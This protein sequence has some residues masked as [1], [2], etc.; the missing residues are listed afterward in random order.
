MTEEPEP[1]IMPPPVVAA[2]E[3]DAVR[4]D[5]RDAV[6]ERVLSLV[7][8]K[9]VIQKTCWIWTSISKQTLASTQ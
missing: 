4:G 6:K 7:V 5:A 1:A 9:P 8:E 3:R 2:R